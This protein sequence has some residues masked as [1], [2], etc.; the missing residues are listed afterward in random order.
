MNPIITGLVGYGGSGRHFHAP[1]IHLNPGFIL[2]SVVER[3]EQKASLDY[4][5]I[6][7]VPDFDGLL[8]DP[9]IELIVITTPNQ[10]HFALA[11]RA[12]QAG[13]HVILEKPFTSNTLEA[14]ELIKI[15]RE[16]GLFLGVYQ[17]RRIEGDFLTIQK[18]IQEGILGDVV[19][20]ESHFDRF[21]PGFNV[22]AWKEI[23]APGTGLVFDLG[24]HLI[25][26]VLVLFGLPD[27]VTAT[28]K[29]FRP[30]SNVDDYF[31][32]RLEY[33]QREIYLRSSIF[34]KK[35]GPRFIIH[36]KKGS[37]IKYGLDPQ[38][39]L[40]MAGF[41]PHRPDWAPEPK[42]QWGELT[43]QLNGI[44]FTGKVPTQTA[45]Y[46]QFYDKVFKTIREN[47]PFPIKPEQAYH[48][49]RVIELALES[50]HLKK[51]MPYTFNENLKN[52][53]K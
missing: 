48:T 27:S 13:K 8:A 4:P 40:L 7:S 29:S 18:I 22:K 34:V 9:N 52:A 53:F 36:G 43:T 44:E 35:E 3:N 32:I 23:K 14:M 30:H 51:T 11:V 12:L 33:P 28:I 24:S 41:K 31:S 20:F 25:D 10:T 21:R 6:Q 1:F 42:E 47:E 38:E 37:F 39:A 19:D 26:Q 45:T 50:S 49:I 16:K 5:D 15:S 46:M 17:N 2:K